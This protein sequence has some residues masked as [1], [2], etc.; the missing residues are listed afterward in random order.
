LPHFTKKIKQLFI[1]TVIRRHDHRA[2]FPPDLFSTSHRACACGLDLGHAQE[3]GHAPLAPRRRGRGGGRALLHLLLEL[4][5]VADEA[6]DED[7]DDGE[8]GDEDEEGGEA[9][10]G[11]ADAVDHLLRQHP[12]LHTA[13]QKLDIN[14]IRRT[15]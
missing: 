3:G 14:I 1:K 9:G 7:G 4:A 13:N 15:Q 11:E 2:R 10:G 6:G 12:A 8:E 5:V